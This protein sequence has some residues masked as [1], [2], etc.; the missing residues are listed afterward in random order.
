M[1]QEFLMLAHV[2][3][4]QSINGWFMSEKL[5]GV[6][7]YWDGGISRGCLAKRVPYCN[8]VKDSRLKK[9]VVA[10]GL[11]SRTGK[12]I[13][14]PNWWLNELPFLPLDGELYL[15]R[16]EFQT[17]TSIVA[18]KDGSKSWDD[19]KFKVFD[20]PPPSVMYQQRE[21]TVRDYKFQ[22]TAGI[23]HFGPCALSSWKYHQVLA[24]LQSQDLGGVAELLNQE[25][26]PEVYAM[27]RVEQ[28]L[29]VL[30]MLGA[31][32]VM[33]RNPFSYWTTQRSK[34]LLK[35]KPWNDSEATIT[36]FTSGRATDKGSR[37]LGKIGA[38]IV[39][40]KGKRL[41]LSGL[42]DRERAFW[43]NSEI[44]WATDHPGEDMPSG[45][46]GEHFKVGDVVT[47][48]YRELS[49][50]GIPKEARFWRGYQ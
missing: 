16:G 12:V 6:R 13:Q 19:I 32:G 48:K 30:L 38:L 4:N 44:A 50:E 18:T 8:V 40:Y 49:D 15:G 45:F 5:D 24:W 41:E 28:K 20:S 43:S 17:L 34:N 31:E 7:A 14:A 46:R 33:L 11:F 26:L 1:K 23:I 29:E 37:L 36:G 10:T 9:E 21:I 42:T 22:V 3:K 47:F 25:R 35:L 27:K 39:S 2:F